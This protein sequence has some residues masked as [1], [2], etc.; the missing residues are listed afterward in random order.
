MI[1]KAKILATF[2]AESGELVIKLQN[3]ILELEK[4]ADNPALI[5]ELNRLAHTLKG[6]ARMMGFTE[7]Q[8]KAHGIE[9]VFAAISRQEKKFDHEVTTSTLKE[10]DAIIALL[11]QVFQAQ[12]AVPASVTEAPPPPA[13]AA[14]AEEYIRVPLRRIDELMNLVGEVIVHK[15]KIGEEVELLIDELQFKAREMR[16]L[17]AATI[18]DN[19]PRLVRDIAAAQHKE[20]NFVVEGAETEIDKSIL[21][22]INPALIHLL[23]NAVDHGVKE[24]GTIRLSAHHEGGNILIEVS[25]DG[26]GIDVNAIKEVVL[27]KNL[28]SQVELDKMPEQEIV[29]YIF[30][31]GFSTSPI[32]TDVSGRGVGMDVVK[33]QAEKVRGQVKVET[34]KGAGTKIILKLPLTVAIIRALFVSSA[35]QVFAIPLTSIDETLSV[36]VK[37]LHSLENRQAFTLRE[38]TIPVADLGLV[39]GLPKNISD[40]EESEKTA[41][42]VIVSALD[43]KLGLLVDRILQE[44]EIYI[45]SIGA[46]LGDLKNIEGAAIVGSGEVVV[47]LDVPDLVANAVAA[48]AVATRVTDVE[49]V[50]EAVVKKLVLVVEDSFTT[51]ELEKSILEAQGYQVE[52][53]IDGL[54]ALSKLS[55]LRPALIVTDIQMPK[56]DGFVMCQIIKQNESL[57]HIPVIMVTALEREEDKRRGIEVGA[58]AYITKGTFEQKNLLETVERLIGD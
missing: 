19:Y 11:Q 47:V 36:D 6:A 14:A 35:G 18:F 33:T 31:P 26:Q 34:Q 29:G 24:K 37:E 45:K 13:T 53:A 56:M 43:K 58:D 44:E 21:E 55:N 22:E 41:H 28:A 48:G 30:L 25:D 3:G 52:T 42:L 12:P 39:L 1:D 7:I 27:K 32:I 49:A 8:D 20:V 57:K 16:M 23:R 4:N 40:Q 5:N 10:I 9:D 51:R 46:Y 2:K 17:Q 38:H 15:A 50:A 54:D